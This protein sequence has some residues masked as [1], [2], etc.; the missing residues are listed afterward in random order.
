MLSRL[1]SLCRACMENAGHFSG[2]MFPGRLSDDY[3]PMWGT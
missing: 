2:G 3:L 1:S